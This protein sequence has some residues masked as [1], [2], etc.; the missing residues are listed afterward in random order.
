MM[1]TLPNLV[2]AFETAAKLG[3]PKLL[4][5]EDML[6]DKPEVQQ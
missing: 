3:I 5:A 4:D 6:M 1:L 2:P